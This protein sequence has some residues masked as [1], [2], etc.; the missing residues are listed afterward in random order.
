MNAKSQLAC[1][2]LFPMQRVSGLPWILSGDSSTHWGTLRVLSPPTHTHTHLYPPVI[3]PWPPS[4]S[5]S[6]VLCLWHNENRF[7]RL[8]SSIRRP[9]CL[10]AIYFSV[11]TADKCVV[12]AF[13][14]LREKGWKKTRHFRLMNTLVN[15]FLISITKV[16]ISAT[17]CIFLIKIKTFEWIDRD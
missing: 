10:A 17:L 6:S 7:R 12:S 13:F 9:V 4:S 16:N 3:L 11:W 15:T 5:P 14:F 1:W 8:G 2:V